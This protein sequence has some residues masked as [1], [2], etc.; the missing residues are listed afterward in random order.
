MFHTNRNFLPVILFPILW[1][2]LSCSTELTENDISIDQDEE[3][4]EYHLQINDKTDTLLLQGLSAIDNENF[5]EAYLYFIHYLTNIEATNNKK[6]LIQAY[7]EIAD[8]YKNILVYDISLEFYQLALNISLADGD[9]NIGHI[10]NAIGGLYYDQQNY[11]ISLA[12]YLKSLEAYTQ[13][14]EIKEIAAAYN[15]IGEMHRFNNDFDEALIY[16]YKALE[17]NKKYKNNRYLGINYGNIGITC[18]NQKKYKKAI[19]NIKISH[20]IFLNT[21]DSSFISFSYTSLGK[22]YYAVGHYSKSIIN[23][24][25]AIKVPQQSILNHRITKMESYLGI[26]KAYSK[27]DSIAIAFD[28]FKEYTDLKDIIFN[29][30][31][32]KQLFEIQTKYETKQKEQE[33]KELHEVARKKEEEKVIR[34]KY[35]IALISLLILVLALLV[36]LYILK[37]TSFKQRTLL[38][39]QTNKMNELEIKN[40]KEENNKLLFQKKELESKEKINKLHQEKLEAEINHKE[41]ELSTIALYVISKNEILSNLKKSI[42]KHLDGGVSNPDKLLS[43]S[44]KEINNS[45]NLD[46]DWHDFKLHFEK[47]HHGFFNRLIENYPELSSDEL[48][49]CAYLRINLSSKEIAQILNITPIAINK[50]RNRLRKKLNLESGDDLFIFLSQI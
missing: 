49:F 5:G 11:D 39:K 31:K 2:L 7:L 35:T 32:Q 8:I 22:Y 40:K 9:R 21:Q 1:L 36:Y 30:N 41:R 15:N 44:I 46:K 28:Y 6:A 17:I 37:S 24:K 19:E 29:S 27:L 34:S 12:Y 42:Q 26:S 33:I 18:L 38:F 25:N 45:I 10:Y 48:K 16:Y 23:Y 3:N 14:N 50:R 20:E 13:N 4:I 47:V 43:E